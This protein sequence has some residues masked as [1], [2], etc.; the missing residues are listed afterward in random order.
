MDAGETIE[1][2]I[3]LLFLGFTVLVWILVLIFGLVHWKK[4]RPWLRQ[5]VMVGVLI[6]VL[7]LPGLLAVPFL[8]DAR[9]FLPS[10]ADA[11]VLPI[12]QVIVWL[13]LA[14][15]YGFALLAAFHVALQVGLGEW[16]ARPDKAYPSLMGPRRDRRGW[17]QAAG[18]GIL[19]TLVTVLLFLAFDIK[20]GEL[21]QNLVKMMPALEDLSAPLLL[22][23]F[24]PSML[25]AAIAEE[26]LFRGILQRGMIRLLGGGRAATIASIVVVSAVWALGHQGVTDPFWAKYIQIFLVGLVF[27]ALAHR[28]SLESAIVAHL[29]LNASALSIHFIPLLIS[30]LR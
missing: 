22:M 9:A 28:R 10:D 24:G 17:G 12:L 16:L 15:Q 14:L 19:A 29:A 20:E 8:L 4:I 3:S 25:A 18:L 27:G 21:I 23:I 11:S 30:S 13:G 1:L 5:G 26:I 2:L 7:K 6:L